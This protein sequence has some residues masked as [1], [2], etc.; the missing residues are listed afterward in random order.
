VNA[1]E[2][3][4]VNEE[5]LYFLETMVLFC[6]LQ[7]SP[8]LTQMEMNEVDM[9]L[10]QV[11]HTGRQPELKLTRHDQSVSLKD[12]ALELCEAMQDM[13]LL[14]DEINHCD[15]YTTSLRAQ[16]DCINDP[17]KTPSARMLA[18]MR[19][20]KEGFFHFAQRHSLQ[21]LEY[22]KSRKLSLERQRFFESLSRE[23]LARQLEI[24]RSDSLNFDEYLQQYFSRK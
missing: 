20:H 4:G 11:A 22:F 5:Q 9:N 1:F 24:E 19:S 21:Y 8:A 12:W 14:L 17:A 3:L 16:V 18:E 15:S 13:A 10:I 23:S 7:D 2:P 6:L